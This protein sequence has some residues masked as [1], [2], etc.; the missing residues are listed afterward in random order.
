MKPSLYLETSIPSYLVARAS[1]D[2]VV[3]AHQELTRRWWEKRCGLY[4]IYVSPTVLD[5]AS[6][7]DQQAA[8]QRME[9][10]KAFKVLDDTPEIERLTKQYHTKL[11]LPDG[12]IRDATHLAFACYYAIDYLMTWNCAH[13][14][15]AE[16]VR[17]LMELN[18]TLGMTTPTICTLEELMGM[19]GES[20]DS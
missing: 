7:G 9:I 6:R 18:R 11:R 20:H 10:L 2:I 13:I 14:A 8:D 19:E 15:N 3:L 16:N 1:R 5:E 17:R 4:E 12:A